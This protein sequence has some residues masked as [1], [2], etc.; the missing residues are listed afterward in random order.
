M[1][2]SVDE[3]LAAWKYLVRSGRLVSMRMVGLDEE[4]ED[5]HQT[6]LHIDCKDTT[7]DFPIAGGQEM[8]SF[9]VGGAEQGDVIIT[10]WCRGDVQVRRCACKHCVFR[11]VQ[12]IDCLF[13]CNVMSSC[14]SK[15]S[16]KDDSRSQPIHHPHALHLYQA[17]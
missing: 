17:S 1:W 3:G 13:L 4:D 8:G 16:G 6:F 5:L 2:R 15:L 11:V 9:R 12:R 14:R 7:G 10:F